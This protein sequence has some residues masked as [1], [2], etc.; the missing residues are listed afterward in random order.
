[1]KLTPDEV[2]RVGVW[3]GSMNGLVQQRKGIEVG[4]ATAAKIRAGGK[5]GTLPGTVDISKKQQVL[6]LPDAVKPLGAG[7]A[8]RLDHRRRC[9]LR[10]LAQASAAAAQC[11]DQGS[12]LRHRDGKDGG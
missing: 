8:R 3:T 6:R 9:G 4:G 7:R 1:M 2:K 10:H 12:D 11:A 5:P